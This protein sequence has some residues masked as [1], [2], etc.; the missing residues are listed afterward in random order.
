MILHVMGMAGSAAMAVA[1]LCFLS[2]E[3]TV[4]VTGATGKLGRW[5]VQ[6]LLASGRP[7]RCLVRQA[8]KGEALWSSEEP[9]QVAAWLASQGAELV[10]GEVTEEEAVRRLLRGCES[11]LALHG[12]KRFTK[13]SDW[14]PWVDESEEKSHGR[15]VNCEA[16]TLLLKLA[17]EQGCKRLVRVT[18]KARGDRMQRMDLAHKVHRDIHTS[19]YCIHIYIYM[20][21]HM[22]SN[23]LNRSDPIIIDLYIRCV[24]ADAR[25]KTPGRSRRS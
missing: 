2:A 1:F 10:V 6:Q 12:A 11:C 20:Y 15:Q 23:R 17:E 16:M 14:L 13:V 24:V 7:V 19:T 21:R 3:G 25:A 22:Y 9:G 4:A 18:G 8:P 5:A